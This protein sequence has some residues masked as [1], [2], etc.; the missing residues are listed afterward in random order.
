MDI[1]KNWIYNIRLYI[2]N[3]RVK[4]HKD[5]YNIDNTIIS[6]VHTDIINPIEKVEH[7]IITDFENIFIKHNSTKMNDLINVVNG[8]TNVIIHDTSKDKSMSQFVTVNGNILT[9]QLQEGDVA[10]VG[11]NGIKPT[12]LLVLAQQ[13]VEADKPSV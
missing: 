6:F 3:L 13:L 8:L 5:V 4:Y 11:I 12:D 2:Y 9:I 10:V 7:N 1:I